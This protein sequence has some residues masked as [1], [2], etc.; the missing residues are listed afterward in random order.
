MKVGLEEL[1]SVFSG[2]EPVEA[3]SLAFC[4]AL[5]ITVIIGLMVEVAWPDEEDKV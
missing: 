1:R 5:I 2:M 4:F 3:A